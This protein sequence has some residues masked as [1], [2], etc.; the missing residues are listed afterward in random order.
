MRVQRA[1]VSVSDKRGLEELGRALANLK[2]EILS[3][4]GTAKALSS[5]GI[6]VKQVADHTGAP[7]I[8][9]GRVKTLHPR[10]HGGILGRRDLESDEKDMAAQNIAPIDLV[11]VNLYPFREAVARGAPLAEVTEEIDIGGPSMIRSAAKN[12]AHVAVV[13]DPDDYPRVV[14]ALKE[15]GELTQELRNELQAKAFAHTAAY[16]ASIS[17]YFLGQL[18]VPF[19]Q[20]LSRPFEKAQDLRYGENPH[21]RA[22]LYKDPLPPP[23]PSVPFATVLQGKELSY[24]NLLDLDSALGCVKEFDETCAVIIK[25]NTPCGVAIGASIE[26]AYRRARAADEVSAFGGIV[27][28]NRPVDAALA[29]ALGE[30]FLECVIA[31]SYATEAR[32]LLAA[33]KNLRLLESPTLAG[34]RSTWKRGGM[35]L[36]GITGGMLVQDRDVGEAAELKTAGKLAPTAEQLNDLRFA[37]K[38]CKHVRSNAIVFAKGGQTVGI[39]GGQTSRVEAVKLAARKAVLPLAGTA[40]ASD[41]F[42]PFRDGLDACADAGATSCVQ[43]GG[44]VR[45]AEVFAAADERGVAMVLTGMRHFRH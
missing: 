5:L 22:A 25:H 2:I 33:K 15:K 35:E 24:N 39:G 31:P 27:A 41:A 44:S 45:D 12:V 17:S 3:T 4:G 29:R 1:L 7:E 43:P 18:G 34:P 20:Q 28:V 42:F 6:P 9:G 36:R 11:V 13:V 14:S 19:P 37:W 38:V 16:D 8:L 26:D 32:D 30:T 23:E 40:V 21:Q 10:I